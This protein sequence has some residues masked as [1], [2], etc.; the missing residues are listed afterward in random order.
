[1]NKEDLLYPTAFAGCYDVGWWCGDDHRY[2]NGPSLQAS[3]E[4]IA[5]RTIR[6]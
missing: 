4:G 1:M 2:K 3:E 6:L 5:L